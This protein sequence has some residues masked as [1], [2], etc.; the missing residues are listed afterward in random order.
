M[1]QAFLHRRQD[2]P[3]AAGL[4]IN[5]AVRMQSDAR[6]R[7]REKIA[8]V[9]APKKWAPQARENARDEK[10]RRRGVFRRRPRLD[11]LMEAAER[12]TAAGKGE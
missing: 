6:Q 9:Q 2:F 8:P 3:V 1:A 5:D 4:A 12:E 10:G 11:H 7:W